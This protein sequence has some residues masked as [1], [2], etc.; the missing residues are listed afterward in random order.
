MKNI[1]HHMHH[2]DYQLVQ[3]LHETHTHHRED[4]VTN[5]QT[6]QEVLYHHSEAS[7]ATKTI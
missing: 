6:N 7:L 2:M 1:D 5:Y 4:L 3:S